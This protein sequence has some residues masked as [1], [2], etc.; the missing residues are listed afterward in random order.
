MRLKRY[1]QTAPRTDLIFIGIFAV[2]FAVSA[3][4]AAWT[5][6]DILT[7]PWARAYV[8]FVAGLIPAVESVPEFSP[9]P[10]VAQ[11]YFAVMWLTVPVMFGI[12]IY[13]GIKGLEHQCNGAL[14]KVRGKLKWIG[15]VIFLPVFLYYA[16][17]LKFLGHFP[18]PRLTRLLVSSRCGLEFFGAFELV[19]PCLLDS[20][21]ANWRRLLLR[22]TAYP[23]RR[24]FVHSD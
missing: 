2:L 12:C 3:A 15:V 22:E 1:F 8:D 4:V 20:G 7:R 24:S 14:R 13:G 23:G 6:D 5:P 18:G 10:G 21:S 17:Y 9:L 16:L 11:F 19:A